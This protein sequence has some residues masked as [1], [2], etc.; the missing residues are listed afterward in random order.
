MLVC[1]VDGRDDHARIQ[2]A[3]MGGSGGA[4]SWTREGASLE[5]ASKARPPLLDRSQALL[6]HLGRFTVFLGQCSW[7]TP[8]KRSP[9][10]FS[11]HLLR[12][13]R[14]PGTVQG[15]ALKLIHSSPRLFRM[16]FRDRQ[17]SDSQGR[18][19]TRQ[20]ER[21]VRKREEKRKDGKREREKKT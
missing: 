15:L 21:K 11:E 2:V 19:G 17:R 9:L 20:A 8:G 3:G 6:T 1:D 7:V 16:P 5:V 18:G 10:Q 13:R 4:H 14:A 12:A